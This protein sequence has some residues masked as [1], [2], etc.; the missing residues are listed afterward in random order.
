MA[1]GLPDWLTGSSKPEQP[2]AQKTRDG[3]RIAPDRN[4]RE[5]CYESRD[6]FFECLDKNNILDAIREDEKSRKVCPQEV[7]D[8]ERDCARSWIKYFKEKR[9][10][11]WK[12]DQTIAQIQKEDAEA[13]RKAKEGRRGFF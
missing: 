1:Y 8:Y 10:Q 13:A 2:T 9:I 12:R 3:G 5:L 4:S 11:D 7:A 6:I